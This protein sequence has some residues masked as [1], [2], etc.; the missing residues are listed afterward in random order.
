MPWPP[1]S[2]PQPA[3]AILTRAKA[4]VGSPSFSR[5]QE[6]V[7][8]LACFA[9]YPIDVRLAVVREYAVHLA[10]EGQKKTAPPTPQPAADKLAARLRSK[11]GRTDTTPPSGCE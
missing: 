4:G 3:A 1:L 2:I 10:S 6:F 8:A 5:A 11:T 9:T 7:A